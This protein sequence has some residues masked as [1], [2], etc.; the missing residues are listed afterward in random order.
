[1]LYGI[2]D[3]GSNTIRLKIYEEKNGIKPLISKKQTAG[4]ISYKENGKLNSKGIK[5]LIST[6]KKFSRYLDILNV[7]KICF[8]ATASIRNIT[9]TQEVVDKVKE[10]T[11]VKIKVLT[12]EQEAL[13][14][15]KAISKE[16][17]EINDGVLIDVG[18]GSSEITLFEEIP[19][20]NTSLP[21]GSLLCYKEFVSKMFPNLEERQN[22]VDCVNKHIEKSH[23]T[24]RS[25][26]DLYGVGGT[27]RTIKK[28]LEELD[29]K[30]DK[31]NKIPID[32]LDELLSQLEENNK[33]SYMK[34]L[35]VKV[36]RIHTIVPGIL[37]VKTIAQYY[38]IKTLYVSN[39]SIREGVLYSII[40]GEI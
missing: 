24:K 32:L 30:Q 34:V 4:L 8:F 28:L 22:I 29:I 12:E 36:E 15:Y 39:N 5:V 25:M 33:E 38:N 10:K 3:I 16:L 18:G 1:M 23:I 19:I 27:I 6:I 31:T 20:D 17:P 26:S 9:N 35:K 2:T 11:G 37:I 14:S 21:I 40:D 7:D 13:W